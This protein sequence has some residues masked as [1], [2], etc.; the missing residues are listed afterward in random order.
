MREM[1]LSLLPPEEVANSLFC[2][3]NG[4]FVNTI[5]NSFAYDGFSQHRTLYGHKALTR[6]VSR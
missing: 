6:A 3:A 4:C 2:S 1:H 5:L